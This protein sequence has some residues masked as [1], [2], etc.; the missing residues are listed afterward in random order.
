MSIPYSGTWEIAVQD[1]LVT[2]IHAVL[3]PNKNVLYWH[4]RYM[5][6]LCAFYNPSNN[7]AAWDTAL[8]NW[9]PPDSV[10]PNYNDNEAPVIFCGGHTFLADG[11]LIIAGGE[12]TRPIS[13]YFRGLKY[14]YKYSGSWSAAGGNTNP[15]EMADGRWY[16]SVTRLADGRL[17]AMSGY[18]YLGPPTIND[19]PEL[20]DP[21]ENAQG[22]G[23][24]S[25]S[26]AAAHKDIPL[27]PGNHL[28]PFGEYEGC[29]L[30]DLVTWEPTGYDQAHI[31]IPNPSSNPPIYWVPAGQDNMSG[32]EAGN[33]IMCLIKPGDTSAKILNIGGSNTR[34]VRMI[35]IGDK[36][37]S[38]WSTLTSMTR[39]R[40]NANAI[41]L[42]DGNIMVL[43]SANVSTP[44]LLITEDSDPANWTWMDLAN[45][46][47]NREYHSTALLLHNGKVWVGGSRVPTL[48][49]GEFEKDMERRIEIYTPYYLQ[50][51]TDAANRPVISSFDE[52]ISYNSRFE[53]SLASAK[54]IDSF[55]LIG[56]SSVTHAFN[57]NQRNVSLSF[58]TSDNVN[59]LIETPVNGNIAPPGI[60]MLFAVQVKSD[61]VSGEVKVPSVAVNVK[62]A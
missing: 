49:S 12:R 56:L 22:Y 48:A 1:S 18:K 38:N 5:P 59:Y 54:N 44:E 60:Y 50:N 61:S 27:Y 30:Y 6:V 35:E 45:M 13:D 23:W 57:M 41:V 42:P 29:V 20:Y 14:T 47:V 9:P 55:V 28:I 31:F 19:V 40:K 51:A 62:I 46:Q 8:P 21:D 26:A 39:N 34:D 32:L 37:I 52:D 53:L 7:T 33:S 2:A 10:N 36:G 17:I 3:L 11:S 25:Y 15:H 43:G 24:T 4:G 16:P 58:E